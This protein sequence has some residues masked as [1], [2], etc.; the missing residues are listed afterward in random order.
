MPA[1]RCSRRRPATLLHP[2]HPSS[3]SSS[4]T[5]PALT[6]PRTTPPTILRRSIFE[7]RDGSVCDLKRASSP[8]RATAWSRGCRA[9]PGVVT[10]AHGATA[11]R[12]RRA[13]F[14]EAWSR[15]A[16]M[17]HVSRPASS[18][19]VCPLC[20]RHN[21]PRR[22]EVYATASRAALAPPPLKHEN[23]WCRRAE[24]G[25]AW[26]GSWSPCDSVTQEPVEPMIAAMSAKASLI[27]G[28]L[29]PA[30][31]LAPTTEELASTS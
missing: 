17:R 21:K 4:L 5:R 8:G 19:A 6:A 11:N 14:G 3:P 30:A 18:P 27:A 31:H 9:N 7:R 20:S 23:P 1:T 25:E 29:L 26:C 10:R 22:D 16:N 12:G 13:R 2:D 15:N 28:R 24:A